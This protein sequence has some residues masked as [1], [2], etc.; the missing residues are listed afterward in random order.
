VVCLLYESQLLN[1][2]FQH[3]FDFW[4][5]EMITLKLRS[6]RSWRLAKR[7]FDTSVAHFTGVPKRNRLKNIRGSS[8]LSVPIW[9]LPRL[10]PEPCKTRCKPAL[11]LPGPRIRV[12][13]GRAPYR[14]AGL[15]GPTRPCD[16]LRPY[17]YPVSPCRPCYYL[18]GGVLIRRVRRFLLGPR[19]NT[20]PFG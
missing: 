11:A 8:S 14:R 9:S 3:S 13:S 7:G 4:K 12:F 15:T 17:D 6:F 18:A 10:R 2:F 1:C 5:S 16:T 19:G 20:V